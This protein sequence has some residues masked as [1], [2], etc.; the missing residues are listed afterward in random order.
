ML[1]PEVAA[2]GVVAGASCSG[3]PVGGS[4]APLA[5][6]TSEPRWPVAAAAVLP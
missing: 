5:P 2:V 1:K 3:S 6:L 4:A